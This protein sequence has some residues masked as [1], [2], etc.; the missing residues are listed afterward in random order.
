MPLPA[1]SRAII[2]LHGRLRN[3][4]EYYISAN[5]AQVA[6]GNDGKSA[7]MIVPQFLA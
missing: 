6:A 2:V 7:I 4:D 5:T 3:A 1:I